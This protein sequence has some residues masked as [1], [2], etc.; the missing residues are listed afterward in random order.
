MPDQ[1]DAAGKMIPKDEIKNHVIIGSKPDVFLKKLKAFADP[2]F[3]KLLIHNV[4]RKQEEFITFFGNE[5][6]PELK[7]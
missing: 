1:F 2:G 3:E 4:N 7:D 6:I 5:V